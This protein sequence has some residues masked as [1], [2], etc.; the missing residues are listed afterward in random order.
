[1]KV[2]LVLGTWPAACKHRGPGIYRFLGPK[3]QLVRL[4]VPDGT[5][6]VHVRNVDL[7]GALAGAVTNFLLM[8]FPSRL[9]CVKSSIRRTL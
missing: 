6:K 7:G 8:E 3:R 5:Q 1:M 2:D 4:Q 9:E